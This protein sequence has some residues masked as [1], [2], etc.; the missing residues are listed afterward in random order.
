MK[1]DDFFGFDNELLSVNACFAFFEKLL[2]EVMTVDW[3]NKQREKT[4]TSTLLLN[5]EH[6]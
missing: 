1:F 2:S 5:F 3:I 6:F 4:K